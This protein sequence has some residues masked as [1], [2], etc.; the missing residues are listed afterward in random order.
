MSCFRSG[1]PQVSTSWREPGLVEHTLLCLSPCISLPVIK[2][3][4]YLYHICRFICKGKMLQVGHWS[5]E[6][7]TMYRSSFCVLCLSFPIA[8]QCC[9]DSFIQCSNLGPFFLFIKTFKDFPSLQF[10]PLTC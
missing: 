7:C 8:L 9:P 4:V 1:K 3:G 2:F 5:S 10:V 6:H